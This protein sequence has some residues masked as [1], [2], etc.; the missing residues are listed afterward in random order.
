M[1]KILHIIVG[2]LVSA[3]ITACAATP[4]IESASVAIENNKIDGIMVFSASAREK[5]IYYF[6]NGKQRKSMPP[7]LAKKQELPP[8]LQ[9]QIKKHGELPPGL[10][11]KGLPDTLERTLSRLPEGFVRIKIGGDVVLINEKTRVVFDVVW[12]VD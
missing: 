2:I 8:G 11:G 10:A 9:K 12:N 5:I 3:M 1:D 6:K 7:G 4:R